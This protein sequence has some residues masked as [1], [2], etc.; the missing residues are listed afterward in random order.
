MNLKSMCN[1][2]E[3][4]AVV[5][6]A[7]DLHNLMIPSLVG[8]QLGKAVG[9]AEAA[10]GKKFT[11]DAG[12]IAALLLVPGATGYQIGK[13]HGHT[14]E[15]EKIAVSADWLRKSTAAGA[16]NA[17][18]PRLITAL[19]KATSSLEKD[20]S[21]PQARK[22]GVQITALKREI[23][24]RNLD[25]YEKMKKASELSALAGMMANSPVL[26]AQ[27]ATQA[28]KKNKSERW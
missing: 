25:A 2:L 13:A 27:R 18:R 10:A 17:A 15:K 28:Y 4:I 6:P 19:Q 22:R 12:D 11:R 21:H 20:I 7:I 23:E 16:A 26:R 24:G 3:K 14:E 5:G 9:H 8:Y 1:E